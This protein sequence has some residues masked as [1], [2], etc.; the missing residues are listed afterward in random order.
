MT[1]RTESP[2]GILDLISRIRETSSEI[3][4]RELEQEGVEGIVP[5]HGKIIFH[6]FR[7]DNPVPL[8]EVV[9]VC[10]R[11]KSTITGMAVTLE[12]HGY[13]TRTTCRDDRRC[14]LVELTPKGRALR[15]SF[16]E[17]SKGIL[18]LIYL[19]MDRGEQE[20][21]TGSLSHINRN[22]KDALALYIT[23]ENR[24]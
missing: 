5:A 6:L 17:I 22:L 20:A 23:K 1:E 11:A 10:G 13:L 16:D 2:E 21:L 15:E 18:D 24:Q 8:S 9:K 14:V 3:L 4:R 7:K 12:K 19:G